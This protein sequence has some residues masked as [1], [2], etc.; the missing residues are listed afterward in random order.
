MRDTAASETIQLDAA[1][2]VPEPATGVAQFQ[3]AAGDGSR[4]FF[5]DRQRLT[6]DS[7]AEPGQGAGKPDLYE[8]QRTQEAGKTVC[9]LRDL[10]VDHN[11]NEHAAVQGFVLAISSDGSVVYLVAQGR[12]A[13]NENG[14]G[15][16]A[17]PGNDNLYELH[18]DGSH[19]TT[20]FVAT[21]SSED[22][23]EWEGNKI[24][25]T[26][27]LTAR[28]SPSGRYLAFMSSTPAHGLRQ[29]RR[30]PRSE[31]RP[32][33]GGLSLR[34]GCRPSLR[35]V[36]CNPTGARPTGV[37][38][39]NESGEGLGLLV[40]RRKV[41]ATRPRTWLAGNIPGWTAQTL[42]SALFQSRYLSDDGTA[43]LQ[44]PRRTRPRSDQPQ[45]ERL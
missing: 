45:R 39:Q 12:L 33:R 36:S 43:V 35:C 7:T 13:G 9:H 25:N 28:V 30:E 3:G 18:L 11:E 34:F 8:C 5:T 6:A 19:W 1:Q 29:R 17:S 42:A 23:P 27:Y 16:E 10:T 31:R 20:T 15:E 41:W 14:I 38:D 40:D 24:A 22:S 37:L 4:V 26:A 44:Q 21:L 32:R 2:G